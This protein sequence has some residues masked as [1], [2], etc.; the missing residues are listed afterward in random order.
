[1]LI[2]SN[3]VIDFLKGKEEALSFFKL[4]SKDSLSTSIISV[5]EVVKGVSKKTDIKKPQRL[6]NST[7]GD[8]YQVNETISEE[9]Y[10]IFLEA[11]HKQNTGIRDALIAATA[12][13]HKEE[14]A[15]L[16]TK[17]FKGIKGLKVT[18]PY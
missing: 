4:N 3:I 14:L 17:H 11:F 15:T 8:I 6:L 2:D 1:M 18:K 12:K 7:V 9:A 16:N 13:V 10:N 5:M